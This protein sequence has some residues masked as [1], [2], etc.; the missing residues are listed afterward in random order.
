LGLV[1]DAQVMLVGREIEQDR[2]W[3]RLMAIV[4]RLDVV[5]GP[6]QGALQHP[7][8]AI[9]SLS[10]PLVA[11]VRQGEGPALHAGGDLPGA[12]PPARR[13]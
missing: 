12:R 6:A 9:A 1:Q 8:R 10:Q 4:L 5:D 3:L 11:E 7:A 13:P 2:G